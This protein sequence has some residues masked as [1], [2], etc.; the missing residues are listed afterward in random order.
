MTKELFGLKADVVVVA[1]EAH[2][3]V[4]HPVSHKCKVEPTL[5]EVV[6]VAPTTVLQAVQVLLL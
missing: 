4:P 6:E 3:L 1:E 2:I 5:A